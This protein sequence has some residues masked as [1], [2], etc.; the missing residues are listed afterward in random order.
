MWHELKSFLRQE[1]KPKTKDELVAGINQMWSGVTKEKCQWY[2]NQLK[3]VVS[4]VKKKEGRAYG[5]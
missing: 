3:K 4:E 5:Y 1:V 2:I